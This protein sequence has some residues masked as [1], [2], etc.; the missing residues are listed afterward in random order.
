MLPWF[1]SPLLT[2]DS[3]SAYQQIF[4]S[5]LCS[6]FRISLTFAFFSQAKLPV[7][8]ATPTPMSSSASAPVVNIAE[9]F[10][11]KPLAPAV[12]VH[13]SKVYAALGLCLLCCSAG[14]IAHL[15]FNLGG[16]LSTLG[17]I[18]LMVWL[19]VDKD[20]QNINK[21]LA[22]LSAF[23]FLQGCSIGP[24]VGTAL[25]VDPSIL[26]TAFLG[27][28]TVFVCF[29]ISALVAER[30]QYLFLGGLVSSAL[31]FTIL[32][33]LVN[34]FLGSRALNTINLYLGLFI[35]CAYVLYD[36]Q[37]ILEKAA[38][39][40]TDFVWHAVELFLDFINIF[41]RIVILLIESQ[42]KDKKKKESRK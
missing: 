12:R 30:R 26:V 40:N 36:T 33:S 41:V 35:F 23:G 28:T 8:L 25:D 34:V 18:G 10:S 5:L 16:F 37:I 2:C 32:I 22:I 42:D 17:A 3:N 15:M 31:C 13:L 14:A 20:T 6:F 9:I 27:T 38:A 7:L 4:H 39:G 21:R 1:I 11:P 24:L 19:T 29:T